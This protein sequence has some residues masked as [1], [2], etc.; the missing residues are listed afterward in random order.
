VKLVDCLKRVLA[1]NICKSQEFELVETQ[2][3]NVIMKVRIT[4]AGALVWSMRITTSAIFIQDDL[5]GSCLKGDC[6]LRCDYLIIVQSGGND[7]VVF[8]EL[9]RTLRRKTRNK[10]RKQLR[11]SLPFWDYLCSVCKMQCGIAPEVSVKYVL[12]AAQGQGRFDKDPISKAGR[13]G[14]F[15]K[16]YQNIMIKTLKLRPVFPITALI[17]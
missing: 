2:G 14:S 10:G 6:G 3:E 15:S 13:S 4:G 11:R 8:V 7:Y 17:N 16:P 5:K 1:P 9:K 12:I